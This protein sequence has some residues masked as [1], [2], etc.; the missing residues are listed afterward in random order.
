MGRVRVHPAASSPPLSLCS[1]LTV[2]L[3]C[4]NGGQIADVFL[5]AYD[6]IVLYSPGTRNHRPAEPSA[7]PRGRG[8]RTVGFRSQVRV[9]HRQKMLDPGRTMSPS[10]SDHILSMPAPAEV[11]T[12]VDLSSTLADVA[13]D[14]V[15]APGKDIAG[16]EGVVARASEHGIDLSIVVVDEPAPLDSQLRDLATSVG[17]TDGGTVLVLGPGQVGTFSDSIDRVTLE[18]GQDQAYTGDPVASANN[19]LDVVLE[20]GTPWTALTVALVL[21]VAAVLSGTWWANA[22]R[23]DAARVTADR[24]ARG[25]VTDG[26]AIPADDL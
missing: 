4:E 26:G 9:T 17:A 2:R 16:L 24:R 10:P 20:P 15:A 14:G 23:H 19:F 6:V 1:I 21:V 11:P 25:Q 8:I 13:D 12:F 7:P 22:R 5:T 18:A 3:S